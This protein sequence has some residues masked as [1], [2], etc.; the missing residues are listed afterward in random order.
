MGCEEGRGSSKLSNAFQ[1]WR[2]AVFARVCVRVRILTDRQTCGCT[3]KREVG[4]THVTQRQKDAQ[5]LHILT[6]RCTRLRAF[7]CLNYQLPFLTRESLVPCVSSLK[8][9]DQTAERV[10]TEQPL[11][12]APARARMDAVVSVLDAGGL[13]LHFW[14]LSLQEEG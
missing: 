8:P 1:F 14:G 2:L 11:G 4:H 7:P 3:D 12:Q 5:I 9:E 6:Q 10:C 13:V